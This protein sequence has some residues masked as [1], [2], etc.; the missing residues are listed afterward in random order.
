MLEKTTVAYKHCDNLTLCAD[1]YEY[2]NPLAP[3]IL[4][5]HG[6]AL[7]WG[8][9]E[10]LRAE[11]LSLY[12]QAG[13]T[14][15]SID[16][17]LAPESTLSE[18]V[19]DIRDAIIWTRK[20]YNNSKLAVVGSSAGAYLALLSGTFE[21]KPD[22]IISFYGYGSIVGDWY[23]TPSGHYNKQ[24]AVTLEQAYSKIGSEPIAH[25]ARERFTYYLFCRQKALWVQ[26]V[27]RLDPAKDKARLLAY[28]PIHYVNA[29][30]PPTLLLHGTEDTDVP[31][32][33]SVDMVQE[34][35]RCGVQHEFFTA[36]GR[37]HVFDYNAEDS[38]T[39]EALSRVRDFLSKLLI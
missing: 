27:S 31:Y 13:F 37:G 14:V 10:D 34:L 6:G 5:L 19:S 28:C 30:Y 15:I 18:I 36:Y 22:A 25:G 7:I 17:R 26:K 3:I 2:N 16:Y 12:N 8:S 20:R 35:E 11:Q 32:Q 23:A 29:A 4:F 9:R 33:Q 38:L 39:S 1:I 24:P 21:S